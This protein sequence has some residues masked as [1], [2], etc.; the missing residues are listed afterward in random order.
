MKRREAGWSVF[1]AGA[2]GALVLV[3]RALL[4]NW[5]NA[6]VLGGC[7]LMSV[8]AGLVAARFR[9]LGAFGG[10]LG[11]PWAE[12]ELRDLLLDEAQRAARYSRPLSVVGVRTH[13][14]SA[15]WETTV[16]AVDRVT[17]CRHGWSILVLPETDGQGARNL[18]RR[19]GA[20]DAAAQAVLVSL[21]DDVLTGD[22]LVS[23]F[24]DL[25]AQAAAP[26]RMWT[27]HNGQVQALP[28]IS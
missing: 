22:E 14:A 15:G 19:V 27:M 10:E 18:L 1:C 6:V 3:L 21:P 20:G 24:Q 8:G 7:M 2:G 11:S 9:R 16:R 13:G 23:G 28:L 5:P 25:L 26:G 4:G 17:Q 12:T